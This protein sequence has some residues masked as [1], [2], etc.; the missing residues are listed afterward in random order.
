MMKKHSIITLL[1]MAVVALLIA[2]CQSPSQTDSKSQSA[3]QMSSATVCPQCEA[4]LVD[5]DPDG[6]K[7]AID[8]YAEP[9]YYE[10]SCPGCQGAL[11]T[12]LQ[13]GTL[14]HKCTICSEKPFSCDMTVISRAQ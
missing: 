4:V 10:H 12:L 11:T 6:M 1:A 8:G 9:A 14:K 2:G 3:Q 13:D 7:L 5:P